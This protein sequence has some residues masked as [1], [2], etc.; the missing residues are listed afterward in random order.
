MRL[1]SGVELGNEA[2]LYHFVTHYCAT[3][4]LYVVL[5]VLS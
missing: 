4:P 3:F 2:S 1:V 5:Q